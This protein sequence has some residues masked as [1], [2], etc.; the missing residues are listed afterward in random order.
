MI[1][2]DKEIY[3]TMSVKTDQIRWKYDLCYSARSNTSFPDFTRLQNQLAGFITLRNQTQTTTN[4][5]ESQSQTNFLLEK[6][7]T[8]NDFMS[9]S[10]I[11]NLSSR[12][13]YEFRQIFHEQSQIWLVDS[14][15]QLRSR[16]VFIIHVVLRTR[17]AQFQS[18]QCNGSHF[19]AL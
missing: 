18:C 13:M 6:V 5:L 9:V 7:S 16:S 19:L 15:N 14:Q 2:D 10:N 17:L 3:F 4:P 1:L 12:G 11:Q 8:I